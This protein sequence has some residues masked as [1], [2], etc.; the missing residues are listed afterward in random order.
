MDGMTAHLASCDNVI[1]AMYTH[2]AVKTKY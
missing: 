1:H 2:R